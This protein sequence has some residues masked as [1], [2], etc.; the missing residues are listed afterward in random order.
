MPQ[1]VRSRIRQAGASD[2]ETVRRISAEAY[3]PAYMA[4]LGTIPKPAVEDYGPRVERGQ[5]W[6]LE[7]EE[8]PIGIAVLEANADHLLIYSIAVKP[9]AQ[10][11]GYGR[12]LLDFVDNLA[13]ELGLYEI[14]LYTNDRMERNLTLYKRHGFV[15]AGKRPHPSRPGQVLIDMVRLLPRLT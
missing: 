7:I 5:V 14:R 13:I 9:Y 12:A 11:K 8:E 2:T 4:V 15:P 10:R 6:I 3:I 1:Q